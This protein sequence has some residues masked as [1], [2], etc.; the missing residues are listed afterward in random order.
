VAIDVISKKS[1]M[2]FQFHQRCS[3]H[4]PII[5]QESSLKC[6][7]WGKLVNDY[8]KVLAYRTSFSPASE[9]ATLDDAHTLDLRLAF[10]FGLAVGGFVVENVR[11]CKGA[12]VDLQDDKV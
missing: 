10:S 5:V 12:S 2:S 1:S 3:K 9:V 6:C 8:I 11:G 7:E 4:E